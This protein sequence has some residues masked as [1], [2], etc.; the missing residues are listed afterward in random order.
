VRADLPPEDD[1]DRIP[2]EE[3][4]MGVTRLARRVFVAFIVTFALARSMVLLMSLGTLRDFYLRFGQT[5]VHHLN[6]GI[7][8]L[9]GVGAYLI[10]LR[11]DS[12]GLAR[13]AALYG[14]GLALTFDEFGMWLHLDDVYWQ[15]ASFDAMV[16]I[17]A[18]LGLIMAAPTVRRFR[19]R[20]WVWTIVLTV[21]VTF[22]TMLL[23][24]P[25]QRVHQRIAPWFRGAYRTP[26]ADSVGVID[27]VGPAAG[28][29]AA[30]ESG[31]GESGA[32]QPPAGPSQRIMK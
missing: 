31:A 23:M 16:L 1:P 4:H 24:Q 27:S 32:D 3:L 18:I 15:R 28:Q 7:F 9:S 14:V 20:H 22:F 8:I 30:G 21:A 6:Y 10:F 13:A 29:P 5:H 12:R 25:L 11:P 2:P 17:A 19:L 26:A